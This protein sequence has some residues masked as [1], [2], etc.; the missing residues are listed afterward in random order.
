[1][2]LEDI[3]S[4]R[5]LIRFDYN[6][7]MGDGAIVNDFRI[8]QTYA[9]I[10]A[11][12]R[13]NNKLIITSHFGRP[14][15]GTF[16]ESFSLKPICKYLSDKLEIN[17]EFIKDIPDEINFSN[18]DVA[19]LENARFNIGEKRCDPKLSQR[20]ASL[21]DIFVFDAFGVSHRE[22]CTTVGVTDYLDSVAGLNIKH[23]IN[24][25]K[26][27]V[28]SKSRPMTIII[29]G[30]KVSTKIVLI[31]KL[32]E[33]CDNMILGGGILNTFLKAKGYEVG[34]SLLEDNFIQEARE[35]LE[36][37][38][39]NKILFPSDLLC[40]S[41]K[42]VAN[43]DVSSI[44]KNDVIYDIGT[45]SIEKIKDIVKKSS[46][47]FWNGPLGYIE[48]KPFNRGTEELA[49]SIAEHNCFSIVGGGDTL[50]II[51]SLNLQDNYDCLSTGGGSLLSY[52]EGGSLPILDKLNL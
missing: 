36:S 49:K 6:V 41:K 21:A 42:G 12:L 26:K 30:A 44:S 38:S 27:L 23:E 22:E 43:I 24:T 45:R 50:P 4:K 29:S 13:N 3:V 35:I 7:P 34:S 39:T 46:S 14:I 37:D 19:M 15:E 9:T 32:L 1:V 28:E 11:L 18:Y 20:L 2:Q 52:L 10:K 40:Q 17:I 8:R 47:V 51:E 16:D 48:K 33:K 31:K 5:V 25:I